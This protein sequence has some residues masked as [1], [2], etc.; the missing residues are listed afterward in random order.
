M[1]WPLFKY[2]NYLSSYRDSHYKDKTVMELSYL[3]D[4]NPILM[5][6]YLYIEVP[7]DSLGE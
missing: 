2:K 5:S 1:A 7:L 6:Q 4:E 3:S